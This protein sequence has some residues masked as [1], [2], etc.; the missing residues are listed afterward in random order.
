M[1]KEDLRQIFKKQMDEGTTKLYFI[2]IDGDY[3]VLE[4]HPLN[5]MESLLPLL[6]A[7]QYVGFKDTVPRF[8]K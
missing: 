3:K 6:S 4:R 1:L 5:E 2:L 8:S 7:F